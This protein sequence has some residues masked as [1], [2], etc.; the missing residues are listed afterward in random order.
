MVYAVNIIQYTTTAS[1]VV[2]FILIYSLFCALYPVV[3]HLPYTDADTVFNP[4]V[5]FFLSRLILCIPP[6]VLYIPSHLYKTN[7]SFYIVLLTITAVSIV[8][9]RV[10]QRT[11]SLSLIYSY[12]I[13]YCVDEI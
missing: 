2:F 11:C 13:I 5:L 1:K 4:T 12:T 7:I 3:D 8:L 6:L 10:G 9:N